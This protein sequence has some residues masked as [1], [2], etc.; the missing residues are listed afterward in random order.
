MPAV[1]TAVEIPTAAE[2]TGRAGAGHGLDEFVGDRCPPLFAQSCCRGKGTKIEEK[3]FSA[4][5]KLK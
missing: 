5:C 2:G 3:L 1:A 4:R